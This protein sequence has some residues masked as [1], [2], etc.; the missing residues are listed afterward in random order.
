MSMNRNMVTSKNTVRHHQTTVWDHLEQGNMTEFHTSVCTLLSR[1]WNFVGTHF[2][3][4]GANGA[5][6]SRVLFS[7]DIRVCLIIENYGK[8]LE[9][10]EKCM[11][12]VKSMG[13]LFI[14][15]IIWTLPKRVE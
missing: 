1:T 15:A 9:N 6:S 14:L 11:N 13:K 10:L 4:V 12:A 8:S 3:F 5:E 2:D 7:F